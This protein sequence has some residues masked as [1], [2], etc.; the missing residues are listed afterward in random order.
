MVGAWHVLNI[1]D[2]LEHERKTV[3]LMAPVPKE[4]PKLPDGRVMVTPLAFEPKALDP[5]LLF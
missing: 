3:H 1:R 5:D 2:S 4:L